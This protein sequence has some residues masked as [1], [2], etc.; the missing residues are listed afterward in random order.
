MFPVAEYFLW[1]VSKLAALFVLAYRWGSRGPVEA[2]GAELVSGSGQRRG[3]CR[4]S[5]Y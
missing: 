2:L 3:P 4:I 5:R 1:R